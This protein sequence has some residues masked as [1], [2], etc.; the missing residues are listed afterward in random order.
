MDLIEFLGSFE[1]KKKKE[2]AKETEMGKEV[3]THYI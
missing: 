3:I 1:Q 2:N